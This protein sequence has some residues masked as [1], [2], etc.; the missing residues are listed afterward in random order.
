MAGVV[1]SQVDAHAA[2]LPLR[3]ETVAVALLLGLDGCPGAWAVAALDDGALTLSVLTFAE[4]LA[5]RPAVL[6]ID[7][8]VGLPSGPRLC[9]PAARKLLPGRASSIFPTPDRAVLPTTTYAE[10]RAVSLAATGHS[11]SAQAWNIRRQI[12]SVDDV[13][14]PDDQWPHGPV[15]EAHP[16]LAFAT[17]TGRVAASKKTSQGRAERTVALAG[18]LGLPDLDARVRAAP[19]PGRPDDWLDALACLWVAH[20]IAAGVARRTGPPAG[21]EQRDARGLDCIIWL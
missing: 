17:L 15:A 19:R 14:T 12:A 16:E 4:A 11:L 7:I 3:R 21:A 2:I 1:R 10:G 6:A 8:P 13:V 9:E 20:R 5:L 18:W